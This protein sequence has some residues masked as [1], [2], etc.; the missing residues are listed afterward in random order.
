MSHKLDFN[1]NVI[2]LTAAYWSLIN[3][4]QTQIAIIKILLQ[5][6]FVLVF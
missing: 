2:Q 1:K 6:G 4:Q 5:I 3:F